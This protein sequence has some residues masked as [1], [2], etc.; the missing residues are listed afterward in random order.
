VSPGMNLIPLSLKLKEKFSR[1][2]GSGKTIPNFGS[3]TTAYCTCTMYVRIYTNF[4]L[5]VQNS[6]TFVGDEY[7]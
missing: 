5:P 2:A 1:M 7:V 3:L 4:Y 6:E